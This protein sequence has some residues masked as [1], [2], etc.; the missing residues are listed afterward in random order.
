MLKKVPPRV[1]G[2]LAPP[3]QGPLGFLGDGLRGEASAQDRRGTR[4]EGT[5]GRGI[6]R[7]SRG[8]C[9]RGGGL[10]LRGY[11]RGVEFAEPRARRSLARGIEGPGQSRVGPL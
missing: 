3:A 7:P 1:G 4:V 5:R 2:T 9:L 11:R 8:S 6:R 10:D